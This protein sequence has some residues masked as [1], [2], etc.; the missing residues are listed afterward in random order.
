VIEMDVVLLN[1]ISLNGR[2][3]NKRSRDVY[4]QVDQMIHC[5]GIFM[6]ETTAFNA[7]HNVDLEETEE[8]HKSKRAYDRSLPYLIISDFKGIL[9]GYLHMFRH[10]EEI[11]DVIMVVGKDTPQS[12]ID[13]LEKREYTYIKLDMDT[14]DIKEVLEYFEKEYGIKKIRMEANSRLQKFLI[15]SGYVRDMYVLIDSIVSKSKVEGFD[16]SDYSK[17]TLLDAQVI[18]RE[19]ILSHYEIN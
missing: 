5:D 4:L 18:N 11:R 13:Y 2:S 6:D 15:D 3:T 12:Y 8:M 19:M 9:Q 7:I 16:S 10:R 17:F 1:E 14:F